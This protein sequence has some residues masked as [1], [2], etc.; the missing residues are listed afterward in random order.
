[1]GTNG[2][3]PIL[4]EIKTTAKKK[5]EDDIAAVSQELSPP[6]SPIEAVEDSS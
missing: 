4:Q 5:K 6:R 2:S 1:M 3:F